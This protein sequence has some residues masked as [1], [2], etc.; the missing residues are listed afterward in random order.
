MPR[1]PLL[2]A[3]ALL[4]IAPSSSTLYA[5]AAA[6]VNAAFPLAVAVGLQPLLQA[7]AAAT[8]FFIAP[9]GDQRRGPCV[10]LALMVIDCPRGPVA[11]GARR[12]VIVA[13]IAGRV[14]PCSRTTA[15]LRG[16]E[17]GS[18][19][20]RLYR[21]PRALVAADLQIQSRAASAVL[22]SCARVATGALESLKTLRAPLVRILHASYGSSCILRFAASRRGLS[23]A[24]SQSR[25][26]IGDRRHD[27]RMMMRTA[28]VF[29]VRSLP[30]VRRSRRIRW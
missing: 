19:I 20:E 22:R 24:R 11:G 13:V 16:R 6:V 14:I 25:T 3:F 18:W 23:R 4:W 7:G 28:G 15:C 21:K 27:D 5:L 9:R 10:H 17:V 29:V 8:T 12:G 26:T 2:A 30:A 1:G